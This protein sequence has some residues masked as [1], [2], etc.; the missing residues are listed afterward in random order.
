[1]LGEERPE[2]ITKVDTIY[3]HP[4]RRSLGSIARAAPLLYKNIWWR[5]LSAWTPRQNFSN[6]H[7][8]AFLNR[9]RQADI[10]YITIHPK[11]LFID[12]ETNRQSSTGSSLCLVPWGYAEPGSDA[13]DVPVKNLL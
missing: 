2:S 5:A 1:M 3:D 6:F 10:V 11:L 12:R 9:F 13:D 7:F 4:L 8:I